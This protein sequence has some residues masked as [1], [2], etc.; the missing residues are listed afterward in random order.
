MTMVGSPRIVTSNAINVIFLD[1]DGVLLPF[2]SSGL[3]DL[4]PDRTL[5]AL[6]SI[7]EQS[8]SPNCKTEIVLSSTWRVQERFRQDIL[9]DFHRYGVNQ[10]GP[11]KSIEFY[12]FTDPCMHSERQHEIFSWL[13]ENDQKVAAWVALDDEELLEGD[14]NRAFR[15]TFD[16]HV[17][18]TNSHRGLT[19]QDASEA[20]QLL[21]EQKM[22][23]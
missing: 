3:K 17:V 6:S 2:L 21:Q 11:L 9:R 15:N 8:S 22:K 19:M 18:K 7:I 13:C 12:D 1:I 10:G 20:V 23:P 5:K 14:A 4:F 16:G